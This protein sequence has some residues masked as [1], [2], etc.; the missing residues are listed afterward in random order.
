MHSEPIEIV[1]SIYEEFGRGDVPAL[2]ARLHPEVEVVVHAPGSIPYAGTRQGPEAVER[3]FGELGS[4]MRFSRMEPET[5]IAEGGEVAVRGWEAGTANAT[6]R[7]YES[8]F[9]HVWRIE[10]G[11]VRRMDDFMDSAA[12]AATLAD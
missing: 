10:D 6:G 4:T 3:W 12:V 2:V 11:L 8:G 5:M 7:A 1:R 9:V